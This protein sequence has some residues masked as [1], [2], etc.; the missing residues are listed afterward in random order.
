MF[1]SRL[2][3]DLRPNRISQALERIRDAGTMILDLTES[4]P[5][6]AE[7]RYPGHE[8]VSALS[9]PRSLV[10]EPAPAGSAVS[11]K[12]VAGYYAARSADVDPRRIQLT[13]STS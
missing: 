9:D 5:T 13:E 8:I 6:R 7:L 3:W 10:Y 4:N 11:R 2:H 1:S 12:A